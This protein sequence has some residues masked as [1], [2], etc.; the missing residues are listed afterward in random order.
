MSTAWPQA[1]FPRQASAR[2]TRLGRLCHRRHGDA[3]A[4][5]PHA[6]GYAHSARTERICRWRGRKQHLLAGR[7]RA[8][9]ARLGRLC[10]HRHGDALA[11]RRG[12]GVRAED[13]QSAEVDRAAECSQWRA[14]EH[15]TTGP[16]AAKHHA[17]GGVTPSARRV[18]LQL[19]ALE[20]S[21]FE[22]GCAQPVEGGGGARRH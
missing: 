8:R 12:R 14:T 2:P 17:P 20:V 21:A 10:H 16:R 1:A 19:C 3:L 15:Q 4:D 7:R 18:C 9:P 5:S 6:R 11:A 13:E 22:G